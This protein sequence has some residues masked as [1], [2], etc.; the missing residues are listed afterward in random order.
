MEKKNLEEIFWKD[1]KIV[2]ALGKEIKP[3]IIGT[4]SILVWRFEG[5]K[6]D[7]LDKKTI[8][9][10]H[11]ENQLDFLFGQ[12]IFENGYNRKENFCFTKSDSWITYWNLNDKV[13]EESSKDK[14]KIFEY[15]GKAA[16]QFYK[17]D[18]K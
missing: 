2:N 1:K 10:Y 5:E 6:R 8:E 7:Y 9:N 17:I 12:T 13:S 4:P 18:K 11:F 15:E 14:N 3:E 16:I